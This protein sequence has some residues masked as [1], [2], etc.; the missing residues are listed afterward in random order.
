[1]LRS[2]AATARRRWPDL[3]YRVEAFLPRHRRARQRADRLNAEDLFTK[4]YEENI[5]GDPESRSG[6]G[7]TLQATAVLRAQLPGL[8]SDL[9]VRRLLDAPCGDFNWMSHTELDLDEYIGGDI[10]MDIVRDN[11]K[12]HGREGR[13][14]VHLNL[15]SDPLP[16]ADALFCRDCLIHLTVDQ[17]QDVLRNMARSDIRYLITTDFP[18]TVKNRAAHAGGVHPLNLRLPP[19]SLP[20]PI[21]VLQEATGDEAYPRIM[22]VW[23]REQ[24]AAA[25]GA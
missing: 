19:F 10:V 14:F 7:S 4:F 5:W 24:V 13:R 22:G 9:G 12:K 2:M 6:G 15:M 18:K 3:A 1:M 17:A 8:L 16:A 21:R 20:E 11:T 23:T 25:G